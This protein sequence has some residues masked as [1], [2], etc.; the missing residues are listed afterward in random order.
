MDSYDETYLILQATILS[1]DNMYVPPPPKTESGEVE[2]I[3]T[4]Q[5]QDV[6]VV[7][8]G[9]VMSLQQME[10]SDKMFYK[11]TCNVRAE[12][13]TWVEDVG[14]MDSTMLGSTVQMKR[15]TNEEESD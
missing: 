1:G 2:R 9:G 5:S 15:V 12:C 8:S 14:R 11:M 10:H 13:L 3:K 4:E 6:T 7:P